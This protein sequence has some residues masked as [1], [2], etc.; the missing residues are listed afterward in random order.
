MNKKLSIIFFVII[1]VTS[2][3]LGPPAQST[4]TIYSTHGLRS[5]SKQNDF[6]ITNSQYY[7]DY[8]TENL[9]LDGYYPLALSP[10]SQTAVLANLSSSGFGPLGNGLFLYNLQN[11]SI[12]KTLLPN[13]HIYAD[14]YELIESTFSTDGNLLA[15]SNYGNA[16]QI[17]NMNSGSLNTT[18]IVGPMNANHIAF[19]PHSS[20]LASSLVY[21]LDNNNQLRLWNLSSGSNDEYFYN[22]NSNSTINTMSVAHS[23]DYIVTGQSNGSVILYNISNPNLITCSILLSNTNYAITSSTFSN[24]DHYILVSDG[25]EIYIFDAFNNFSLVKVIPFINTPAILDLHMFPNSSIVVMSSTIDLRT[26]D[27]ST[28]QNLNNIYT[29]GSTP[30]ETCTGNNLVLLGV[31]NEMEL[32]KNNQYSTPS[33]P[34]DLHIQLIGT[35]QVNLT[36]QEPLMDGGHPI[37]GYNVF[38]SE[39][40]ESNLTLLQGI[41][42]S[43]TTNYYHDTNL[44]PNTTYYYKI[45]AYNSLG[46][47]NYS[48]EVS[49]TT[50]VSSN[51]SIQST[52]IT[53]SSAG[54]SIPGFELIGI[55]AVGMVLFYK[56]KLKIE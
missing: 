8:F 11:E 17:F 56:R 48:T 55:L 29:I 26:F 15:A 22:S 19:I 45:T 7:N 4:F 54:S 27:L 24:D 12:Y 30:Y 38:R 9:S 49:I 23:G 31:N 39:N 50:P 37:L 32:L 41:F 44:L 33:S 13:S 14:S 53:T 3:N 16:I 52:S 42:I 10:N 28:M 34:N 25:E 35:D 36:W 47:G 46:N 51:S 2:C 20:Y 18:L 1:L 43:S 6:N 5:V 21:A 40:T